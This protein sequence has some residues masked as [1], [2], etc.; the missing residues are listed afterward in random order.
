MYP[1]G[2]AISRFKKMG[3]SLGENVLQPT[4][5]FKQLAVSPPPIHPEHLRRAWDFFSVMVD[6]LLVEVFLFDQSM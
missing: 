3:G 4:N 5:G 1:E 2:I 6:V